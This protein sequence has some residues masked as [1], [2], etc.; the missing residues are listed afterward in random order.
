MTP[1]SLDFTTTDVSLMGDDLTR[2]VHF[3]QL[4]SRILYSEQHR[5]FAHV[6]TKLNSS[7]STRADEVPSNELTC[8]SQHSNATGN[9]SSGRRRHIMQLSAQY[10][11]DCFSRRLKQ[12]LN[13]LV[14]DAL[15]PLWIK[16][17]TRVIVAF[18]TI[19]YSKHIM[20]WARW[21]LA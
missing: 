6:W 13:E 21:C 11:K 16:H 12:E 8:H 20:F 17:W 15:Y 2:P 7:S 4:C 9:E 14:R 10:K 3:R 19:T 1:A 18:L 5:F